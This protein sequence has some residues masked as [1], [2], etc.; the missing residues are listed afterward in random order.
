MNQNGLDISGNKSI[1]KIK[2]TFSL[3]EGDLTKY[4]KA[5]RKLPMHR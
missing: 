4:R 2:V 1:F 3:S 5:N